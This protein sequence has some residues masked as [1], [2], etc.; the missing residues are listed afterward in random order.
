MRLCIRHGF[1][2][3]ITSILLFL[4][5]S[6]R[7]PSKKDAGSESATLQHR[8]NL[9]LVTI[10]TLRPDRLGC[11][12]YSRIETP[13]LDALAKSGTLF[14]N[15]VT[16]TPLTAPSHASMFTGLYPNVHK[17]RD[18]GGFV[19]QTPH[20][21]L[22]EILQQQGWDT[23][24][25]V[26]SAALNK[27]FGFNRGFAVYDDE[28]PKPDPRSA[29][30]ENPE[31]RAEEVVDRAAVWLASQ[32]RRPYFL[33]VHVYD[34]HF[35]YDPPSPF[36]EKY[37]DRPYDGEVAYTDQQLGR[38][39][40]A[41]ASK[42]PENTLIVVL[43]DHGESLSE[44]GEYTHGVFLYDSTL[45]VAFLMAGPGVPKGLRVKQQARV[46]DLLPTVLELMGG[47][48]PGDVQGMSLTPALRGREMRATYSYAETLYPRI[49][50]GWAELR[51]LRTDRWM[52]VRVPKPELYDLPGDPGETTNVIVSH[53][54]EVRLLEDRLKT[55]IA[56]GGSE[57][58]EKVQTTQV[59]Q[60]TMDQLKS[61]GYLGGA[62][63]AEYSLT[64][65][66]IDPKDRTGVLKSL[67]LSIAPTTTPSERIAMLRR[68]LAGDPAD[69]GLYYHLGDA[70]SKTGRYSQA[71]K[72][73]QEGI[74]NGLQNSWLYSRIG[75]LYLQQGDKRE[76]ISALEKAV[77][78][79]PSDVD[80]LNDLAMAYLETHRIQDSERTFKW[81]LATNDRYA[82]AYNGLGLIAIQKR[83]MDAARGYFEKAAQLDPDLLEAQLN[84]GRIYKN[85]GA[86]ARARACWETFLIKASPAEYGRI[87]PELKAELAAMQ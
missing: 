1:T 55:V 38:L 23:A 24:A 48:A 85:M 22:A 86:N 57:N 75:R 42:S 74:R 21:T 19:F 54:T 13:N 4:V 33:W 30:V 71:L 63:S 59:D 8:L 17:V 27:H 7:A 39:F 15:A 76:A 9:V 35:P 37:R 3:G 31:R 58:A 56:A 65:K 34:P 49:N 18:T 84:L 69:P 2:A 29:A 70:Y 62:S 60:R 28:M 6:C 87:I 64:G 53:P 44:H 41:I 36:R 25:F 20:R 11:Y 81:I 40:A 61:L 67:F 52:Y 66:G 79:D 83:D 47:K 68:A 43:S 46:V 72:L 12:G 5:V 16:H 80:S 26:G 14:E 77:R 45:R 50:H 32:S 78:L 73:Y 82:L 51:G 10:D